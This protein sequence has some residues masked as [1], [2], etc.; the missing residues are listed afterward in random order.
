MTAT[1]YSTRPAF[2]NLANRIAA[3][4]ASERL[5][6][7]N[8][9]VMVQTYIAAE[10]ARLNAI[11]LLPARARTLENRESARRFRAA[12]VFIFAD[13][14]ILKPRAEVIALPAPKPSLL[15]Q[16]ITEM[17]RH[18]DA[19]IAHVLFCDLHNITSSYEG[20]FVDGYRASFDSNLEA[21]G[22]SQQAARR[23][24]RTFDHDINFAQEI[25]RLSD[26]KVLY[27][28][29]LNPVVA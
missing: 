17:K 4:R 29:K 14:R 24:L 20:L 27:D 21:W 3:A 19:Q 5:Y 18:M 22:K 12:K 13:G 10:Q 7:A 15:D 28:A 2:S 16:F 9:K 1:V 8:G 25:V 6:D 26:H 11:P 23:Y